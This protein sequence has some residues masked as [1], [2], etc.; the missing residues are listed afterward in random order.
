MKDNLE[1]IFLYDIY[2]D[3]LTKKQ[4]EIFEE[5]YLYNLSLRE[6]ADNRAISYQAVSDSINKTENMLEQF[7][8]KIGMK[9]LQDDV[10][11]VYKL[12]KNTKDLNEI[13]EDLLKKLN[14]SED[15]I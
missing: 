4:K 12:I 11:S 15:D 3:L 8:L 7:E 1:M 10:Q 6:I 13:K 2:K 5:Y 9:K 14:V